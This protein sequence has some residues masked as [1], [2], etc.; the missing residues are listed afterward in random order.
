MKKTIY[1]LGTMALALIM[2]SCGPGAGDAEASKAP[3]EPGTDVH[4][5]DVQ[6]A[7]DTITSMLTLAEAG[8]WAGYVGQFYGESHKFAGPE[9]QARLVERF[10]TRWGEQIVPMLNK[11]APLTPTIDGQ[12]RALFVEDGKTVFVLYRHEDGRWTFRL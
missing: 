7:R 8:D 10:E 1:L 6:A 3:D 12:G 11:I 5:T 4:S 2:T 9:D